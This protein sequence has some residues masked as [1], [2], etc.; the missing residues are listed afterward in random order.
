MF[1]SAIRMENLSQMVQDTGMRSFRHLIKFDGQ[2][3]VEDAKML[4]NNQG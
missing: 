3:C 4:H 1:P 2:G